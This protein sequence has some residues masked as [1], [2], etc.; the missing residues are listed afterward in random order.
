MTFLR[1]GTRSSPLALAQTHELIENLEE[2]APNIKDDIQIVCIQ[3][4]GD[5]IQDRSLTDVGGKSLFT[6]EVEGALLKGEIDLAVHS[7]KDVTVDI[8]EGLT[9]AAMLKREDP[10]DALV[11]FQDKPIQTLSPGTLFGTSSLR[12][13]IYALKMHPHL[14]PTLLRGNVATRLE[15]VRTG[16]IGATL[17][18][19]AGLKRLGLLERATKIL[20]LEECLPAIAQG[21]IGIQCR[22]GDK[23]IE[24]LLSSVNH[25]PT[26]QVITTERAF[27][28]KLQGSCRT[29]MA[30]YAYLEKGRIF[31]KG[32]VSD[33]KGETIRFISH[34][35]PAI[36]ATQIGEE[37]AQLLHIKNG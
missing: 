26:F 15:K 11:T 5:A 20:S 35:G 10:R 3:T 8:P 6:K 37:A 9:F 33:L 29:P 18:A 25:R 21:A 24:D 13:K 27:M 2:K 1:I 23:A 30:G 4:T 28:R 7:M 32:M 12:R 16:E 17:L 19:V 36:Q 14:R 34:E 31:F 22:K